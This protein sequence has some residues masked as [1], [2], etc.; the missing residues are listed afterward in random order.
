MLS[1]FLLVGVEAVFDPELVGDD[2]GI[3]VQAHFKGVHPPDQVLGAGLDLGLS[4]I[5]TAEMYG[6][7]AAE[8]VVGEAISGRRDE[9]FIMSMVLPT[10]ASRRRTIAACERRLLVSGPTASTAGGLIT[11]GPSRGPAILHDPVGHDHSKRLYVEHRWAHVD[12]R[13][14]DV[15]ES[16]TTQLDLAEY[17]N[18]GGQTA[19]HR[20]LWR[21]LK[22]LF[23]EQSGAP[24]S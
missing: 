22:A 15:A 21:L 4:H 12:V 6:E 7:G 18:E 14:P 20:E 11:L 2:E 24:R 8:E 3:S 10:N 16:G 9:V 17:L 5:D 19:G 13:G 1:T 23:K